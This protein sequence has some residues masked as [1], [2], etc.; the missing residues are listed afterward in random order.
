MGNLHIKSKEKHG[1]KLNDSNK[2]K[3][4]KTKTKHDSSSSDSD[5]DADDF[6]KECLKQHNSY[7]SSHGVPK[8]K[9]SKSVS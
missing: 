1:S 7:R 5:S 2:S 4:S 8:L 9:L 6:E 3:V